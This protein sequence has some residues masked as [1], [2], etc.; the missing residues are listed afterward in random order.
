M[1]Q[2]NSM[3]IKVNKKVKQQ[4]NTIYIRNVNSDSKKKFYS[5][6]KEKELKAKELFE[7]LVKAAE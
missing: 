3:K 6:L 1:N 5:L 4:T 7:I 2:E